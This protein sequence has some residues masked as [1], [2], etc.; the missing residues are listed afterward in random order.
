MREGKFFNNFYFFVELSLFNIFKNKKFKNLSNLIINIEKRFEF[1]YFYSF[2]NYNFKKWNILFLYLYKI[3]PEYNS[4]SK[5]MLSN[6]F[7]LDLLN[8]YRGWRHSRGLPVRGQR[9]WSNAWSVYKSNLILRHFKIFLM[10]RIYNKVS[11]SNLNLIYAAEQ[12]NL[13][14]K[15]QWESEW[16]EAKKKRL[17]YIKKKKSSLKFDLLSMSSGQVSLSKSSK[18]S[19]KRKD[20]YKNIFSL[21]FDS[22]FTKILIKTNFE[23]NFKK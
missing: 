19:L 13:L 9:T 1:F 8:T 15:L 21:G 20:Q 5:K 23:S 7:F 6:I 11:I 3:I 18:S 2:I 14:W 4:I 12:F 22:G 17:L 10:K 16:K